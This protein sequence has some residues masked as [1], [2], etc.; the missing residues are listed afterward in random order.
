MKQYERVVAMI[1]PKHV[2]VA[3]FGG[4]N[5]SGVV[6]QVAARLGKKFTLNTHVRCWK[7][8][9]TRPSSNS[10][11]PEACD[12]RCCYYD[13]VHKD[14][15]YTQSWVDFLVEKLTDAATYDLIV[16]GVAPPAAA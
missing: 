8:F 12:N 14:Y 4:L 15:I 1:K 11:T 2:S 13:A 6:K 10:S 5:A 3:N 16:R 7:H 9:N